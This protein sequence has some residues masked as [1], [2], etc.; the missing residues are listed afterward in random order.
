[1]AQIYNDSELKKQM[2]SKRYVLP[3]VDGFGID[4]TGYDRSTNRPQLVPSESS[5][6]NLPRR[7]EMNPVISSA[8]E[9][10]GVQQLASDSSSP[11]SNVF[12]STFLSA[13]SFMNVPGIA[14]TM[15]SE[16]LSTSRS[17]LGPVLHPP[18]VCVRGTVFLC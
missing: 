10:S 6:R 8:H 14:L 13:A 17:D 1:M 11:L 18:L 9:T 2:R 7:N 12:T 3:D 15:F 4:S 5:S 16:N